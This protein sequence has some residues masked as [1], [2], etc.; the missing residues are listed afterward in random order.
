MRSTLKTGDDIIIT[1]TKNFSYTFHQSR[2]EQYIGDMKIA[3]TSKSGVEGAFSP[4]P[5]ACIPHF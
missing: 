5:V 1:G 3:S 4:V 2:N